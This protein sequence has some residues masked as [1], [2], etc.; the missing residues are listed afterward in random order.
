MPHGVLERRTNLTLVLL[1]LAALAQGGAADEESQKCVSKTEC[2]SFSFL[3]FFWFLFLF[4]FLVS[5]FFPFALQLPFS[6]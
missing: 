2:K 1:V 5:P 4:P 6:N 3:F